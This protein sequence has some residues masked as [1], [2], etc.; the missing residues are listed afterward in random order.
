MDTTAENEY[1]YAV[2]S[3][4]PEF[5]YKYS[6]HHSEVLDKYKNEESFKKGFAVSGTL[7]SEFYQ[8]A[9][10]EGLKDNKTKDRV[11]EE[12]LKLSLKAFLAKQTWRSDGYYYIENDNDAVIKTA[13]QTLQKA[14]Q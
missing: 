7:L 9:D 3:F 8:Y 11:I 2:R 12:K 4:V 13:V 14:A 6:S 5:I 10:T 1:F